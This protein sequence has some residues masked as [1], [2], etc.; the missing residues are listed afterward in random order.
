MVVGKLDLAAAAAVALALL[1]VEHEHRIIIGTP[2]AAEVTPKAPSVCPDS[3]AI[4]FSAACLSY[5]GAITRSVM[6]PHPDT[7]RGKLP[8]SLD[9]RARTASHDPACPPS[10][11]NAP[12]SASCIR[13]MSGWYWQPDAATRVP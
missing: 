10:N 11:E 2:A 3:D 13:F 6:A 7:A 9:D 8:G 4:P 12:Y 5:I 1:W